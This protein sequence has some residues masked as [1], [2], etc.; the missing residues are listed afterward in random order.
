MNCR[1][2]QDAILEFG[3]AP[4]EAVEHVA[5]CEECRGF[6][7]VQ[8]EL[9]ARL[10]RGI[11][12]A[13]MGPALLAGVRQRIRREPWRIWPDWLPD[14]VHL[15]SCGAAT[16][17]CAALLPFPAVST[18]AAGAAVTLATWCLE[19]VFAGD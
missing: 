17:V 14:V 13:V 16:V 12:P 18:L 9:D 7:A 11:R 2:V 8:R 5:G 4:A 1:E 3:E 10:S 6:Q 19:S 15:A